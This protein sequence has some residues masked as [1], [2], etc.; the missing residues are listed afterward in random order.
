M[1]L[2]YTY[3]ILTLLVIA[4]SSDVKSQSIRKADNNSIFWFAPSVD[5]RFNKKWSWYVE[6]QFRSVVDQPKFYQFQ[7]RTA[8]QYRFNKDN[9]LS[10]GYVYTWTDTYGDEPTKHKFIEHRTYIQYQNKQV[11][12]KT[13]YFN[14]YRLEQRL[15]YNN[16]G[17]YVDNKDTIT[18]YKNRFRYLTRFNIPVTKKGFDK[19]GLFVAVY[20]EILIAFGKKVKYNVFDQNRTFVGLGYMLGKNTRIEA[21][22][23][24]QI[25]AHGD[26]KLYEWNKGVQLNIGFTLPLYERKKK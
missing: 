16:A 6:N 9:M 17:N 21:G 10:L 13:E 7:L 23:F 5:V 2:I 11:L 19:G 25:L 8:A 15:Q 26:G 1:K 4:T 14:R 22:A 24:Q 18:V 20:D 12:G 3:S